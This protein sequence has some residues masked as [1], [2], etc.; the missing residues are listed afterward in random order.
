M[1]SETTPSL[2]FWGGLWGLPMGAT[3]SDTPWEVGLNLGVIVFRLPV[4]MRC[5]KIFK[6]ENKAIK[7]FGYVWN[8]DLKQ[9]WLDFI[10]QLWKIQYI[11][12]FY[13][14]ILGKVSKPL[15]SKQFNTWGGGVLKILVLQGWVY[16]INKWLESK[17]WGL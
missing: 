16:V 14:M 11:I 10:L 2:I 13:D 9:L 7:C 12:I 15:F 8:V 6:G 1:G 3:E 17:R 4:V 5:Y